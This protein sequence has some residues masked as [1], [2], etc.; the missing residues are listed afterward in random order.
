MSRSV[1]GSPSTG[2][3]DVAMSSSAKKGFPSDR[4]QM[5]C[6]NVGAV[7]SPQTSSTFLA[8][9]SLVKRASSNRSAPERRASSAR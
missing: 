6:T 1:T 2:V 3:G 4:S 5:V 9:S 7:V 8:S